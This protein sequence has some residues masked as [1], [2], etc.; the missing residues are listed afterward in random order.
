M[1]LI[2][3]A[4]VVL[5]LAITF[6]ALRAIRGAHVAPSP[7]ASSHPEGQVPPSLHGPDEVVGPVAISASDDGTVLRAS[8]GTCSARQKP[9][10][11]VVRDAKVVDVT[12][13]NLTEVLGVVA[14]SRTQLLINGRNADCQPVGF[15]SRDGGATW[16]SGP[17]H[18]MWSLAADRTADVIDSPGGPRRIPPTCAPRTVAPDGA[19][20]AYVTCVDGSLLLV[21][22]K[23]PYLTLARYPGL[24]AAAADGELVHLATLTASCSAQVM[25]LVNGVTRTGPCLGAKRAPTGMAAHGN[26][27]WLQLGDVLMVSVDGAKTFATLKPA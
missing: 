12:V 11:V 16:S 3:V 21:P 10:V 26:T 24:R 14:R 19:A 18:V 23:L 2:V 13:P 7:P 17:L 25:T 8:L 5:D 20:G 4:V 27:V 15:A 6:L 1:R 9:K 22:P